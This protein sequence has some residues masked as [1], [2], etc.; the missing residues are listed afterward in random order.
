M[1]LWQ[2]AIPVTGDADRRRL[3]D[4]LRE[5]RVPQNP[6][7]GDPLFRVGPDGRT[8]LLVLATARVREALRGHGREIEIVRDF[9]DLPDPRRYVSR[10][11]RYAEALAQ[12]RAKRRPR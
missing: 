12:L 10:T 9:A 11:N 7:A 4:L 2:I 1:E 5:L 6:C 8:R 3:L